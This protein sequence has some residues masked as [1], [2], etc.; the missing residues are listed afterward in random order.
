MNVAPT[1]RTSGKVPDAENL[2]RVATGVPMLSAG[3]QPTNNALV[4]N[5]GL[6]I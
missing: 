4:W 1:R 2:G 5:S 6:G 3:D